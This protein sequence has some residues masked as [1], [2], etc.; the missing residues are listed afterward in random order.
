MHNMNDHESITGEGLLKMR[1][2]WSP[3]PAPTTFTSTAQ[4][5]FVFG[6]EHA[7]TIAKDGYSKAD[8]KKYLFEHGRVPLGSLSDENIE[9]RIRQWPV[10]NGE[11]AEAGLD[12]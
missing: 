2:A 6:P 9:R 5:A 3:R 7:A 4:P 10:F 11:F 12:G 1:P 8:V